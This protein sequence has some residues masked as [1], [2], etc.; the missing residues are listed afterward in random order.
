MKS[1][2]TSNATF[3]ANVGKP[4]R[5]PLR[6]F[7]EFAEEFGVSEAVLR[8]ALMDENAPKPEF[9]Q[10]NKRTASNRWYQVG[11]MRKWWKGRK[12]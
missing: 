11:E 2:L 6:T 8:A 9:R 3:F 12:L 10:S 1:G 7:K 4:A 5:P